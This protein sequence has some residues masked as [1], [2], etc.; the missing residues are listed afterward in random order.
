MIQN[1]DMAMLH[2]DKEDLQNARVFVK[3]VF[4]KIKREA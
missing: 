4:E 3:E 2:P 1:F